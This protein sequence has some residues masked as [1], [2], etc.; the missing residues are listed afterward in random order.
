MCVSRCQIRIGSRAGSVVGF[1]EEPP[2]NTRMSA[3][4]GMNFATGSLSS[5][6]PS[7]YSIIAATEVIA[8]VIE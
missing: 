5:N 7:S 3:K 6:A 4:L 8:L 1:A 2:L